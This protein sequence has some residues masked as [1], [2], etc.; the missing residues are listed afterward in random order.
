MDV[1]F[2]HARSWAP[3]YFACWFIYCCYACLGNMTASLLSNRN[4]RGSSKFDIFS[5]L[6][7]RL[8][9]ARKK[10]YKTSFINSYYDTHFSFA[11]HTQ[12]VHELIFKMLIFFCYQTTK[13]IIIC[14]KFTF[15]FDSWRHKIFWHN[16]SS[17]LFLFRWQT[18]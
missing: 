5:R 13:H 16:F 15:E 3:Y 10:N 4:F 11:F 14:T 1:N 8:K 12:F 18:T 2:L 9:L 6:Y 17:H 7:W